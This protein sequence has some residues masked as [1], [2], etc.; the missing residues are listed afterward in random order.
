M[1]LT[2]WLT[3][4]IEQDILWATEASRRDSDSF[5]KDGAHWQWIDP[6]TDEVV[7]LKPML[8][9]YVG[10][11]DVLRVSLRSMEHWPT[12]RCGPLPQFALHAAEEVPTAVGGHIVRHDPAR[13][14]ADLRGRLKTVQRCVEAQRS[15]SPD[16]K[17]F[18][19]EI[20]RDMVE[21]YP[22]QPDDLHD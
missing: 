14:L 1:K 18:A 11:P 10:G 2:D 8:T 19:S 7:E 4:R 6:E 9:E 5:A 22:D 12:E 17:A 16:R 3:W 13:V 20:L 15:G 21:A